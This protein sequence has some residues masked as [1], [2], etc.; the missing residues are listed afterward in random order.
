V[1]AI[2]DR[3]VDDADVLLETDAGSACELTELV[4][5]ALRRNP[6]RPHLLVSRV[7]GKHIPADPRVVLDSGSR[8]GGL[9]EAALVAPAAVVVGYAETATGLGHAVADRLDSDYLHSTRRRVAGVAHAGA[10]EEEHSHATRH[11]LLPEDPGLLTRPGP[12]VLVDDEFSTGS[13]AMNTIAAL[14]ALRPRDQYVLAAHVDVR[15]SSDRARLARFAADLGTE[16]VVVATARGLVRLPDDFARRAAVAPGRSGPSG[17]RPGSRADVH[18][19]RAAWPSGVREGGRH[20]FTADDRRRAGRAARAVA[21]EVAG[22]VVG[23]SILVLGTE[24]LMYAPTLVAA[25]LAGFLGDAGTVLVS[26][27]TRSPVVTIDEPG[28]PIRTAISFVAHDDPVDG[29]T[30]RFAYN[31]APIGGASGFS[32]IVV[33]VDSVADTPALHAPDGLV[34]A[35]AGLCRR[36]TVVVLPTYRPAA[37]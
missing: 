14:H 19:A 6:R 9:V 34:A 31:V 3:F 17:T 32:D 33:V 26:S 13:T 8:L 36:V 11:L 27:T 2:P 18:V 5:L 20:G 15:P 30:A 12:L 28:Y 24:E 25:E 4:A 29:P 37:A 23:E 16:I 7:L 22:Q 1:R 35:V 10:F 21:L